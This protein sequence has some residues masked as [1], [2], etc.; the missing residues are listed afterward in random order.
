MLGSEHS[1][2]FDCDASQQG[3]D[4]L[5]AGTYACTGV[6]DIS[7]GFDLSSVAQECSTTSTT[8]I[9]QKNNNQQPLWFDDTILSTNQD[10]YFGS[11]FTDA[12]FSAPNPN[13]NRAVV[14][15]DVGSLPVYQDYTSA[16]QEMDAE[17]FYCNDQTPPVYQYIN[18]AV[19]S[20]G[21]NLYDTSAA[22]SMQHLRNPSL[23]EELEKSLLQ[24]TPCVFEFGAGLVTESR[25]EFGT[26][27]RTEFGNADE[28]P[29]LDREQPQQD[30]RQE[31]IEPLADTRERLNKQD[32]RIRELE[33]A[34]QQQQQAC[35]ELP[36]IFID[37]PRQWVEVQANFEQY[38]KRFTDWAEENSQANVGAML[39]MKE[40]VENLEAEVLDL[41]QYIDSSG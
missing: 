9:T 32:E 25:I 28:G 15:Q 10:I 36:K 35:P 19:V 27:P 11:L 24:E 18:P 37:I 41:R 20:Q 14:G 6:G 17:L 33:L 13:L 40:R 16:Y 22:L 3:L 23:D 5:D 26:Q 12:N 7:A 31:S 29:R 8:S 34:L 38:F 30:R 21:A 39:R 2:L 1:W 4:Y